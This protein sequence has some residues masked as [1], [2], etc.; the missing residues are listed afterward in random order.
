MDA[1]S[2]L[3]FVVDC[4]LHCHQHLDSVASGL[5]HLL[6]ELITPA[7]SQTVQ[8]DARRKAVQLFYAY[9]TV[10]DAKLA[11]KVAMIFK[12][13]KNDLEDMG[14]VVLAVQD[15]LQNSASYKAAVHI[16]MQFEVRLLASRPWAINSNTLFLH[17]ES[18][19]EPCTWADARLQFPSTGQLPCFCARTCR[20]VWL[21]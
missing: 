1:S 21:L 18:Y 10:Q 11:A 14:R 5:K 20:C 13:H 9:C 16:M 4:L 19:S 2:H 7:A 12:L 8:E 17:V 15:M 3:E 6:L